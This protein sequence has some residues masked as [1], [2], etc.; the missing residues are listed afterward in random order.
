MGLENLFKSLTEG[1]KV[2]VWINPKG[3]ATG[4]RG[5]HVFATVKK[6]QPDGDNVVLEHTQGGRTMNI[7]RGTRIES[8]TK[9][10]TTG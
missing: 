1:D 9:G 4:D 2:H 6:V 8:V 5:T 10:I 3:D 7:G